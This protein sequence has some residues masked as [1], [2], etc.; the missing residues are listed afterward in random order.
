MGMPGATSALSPGQWNAIHVAGLTEATPFV[1]DLSL[2]HDLAMA[3]A[4][5]C[6]TAKDQMLRCL[7]CG[8]QVFTKSGVSQC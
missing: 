7:L 6:V 4:I 3:D 5:V 8:S 2:Q 1:A